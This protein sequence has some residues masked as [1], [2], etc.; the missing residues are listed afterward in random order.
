MK[1]AHLKYVTLSTA[2]AALSLVGLAHA[3]SVEE[4]L[5]IQGKKLHDYAAEKGFVLTKV[6]SRDRSLGEGGADTVK[7]DELPS[8]FNYVAVGV[9]DADCGGLGLT[10]N[11]K[12]G[13]DEPEV[14]VEDIDGTDTPIIEFFVAPFSEHTLTISMMSCSTLI[15]G[16]GVDF[17]LV[18]KT[19]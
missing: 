7:L 11:K 2:F 4:K 16:Y 10:V 6:M 5:V 15:C 12:F 19:K 17:Y 3:E 13:I 8:I 14:F 18:G 1:I 9:C